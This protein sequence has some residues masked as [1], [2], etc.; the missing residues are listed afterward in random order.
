MYWLL[1]DT[2]ER[3]E[4]VVAVH[5]LTTD[6]AEAKPVP[7]PKTSTRTTKRRAALQAM[8]AAASEQQAASV[9]FPA[10]PLAGGTPKSNG[11]PGRAANG[12]ERASARRAAAAAAAASPGV[13]HDATPMSNAPAPGL[14]TP[15]MGEHP[16]LSGHYH[17]TDMPA[18][19]SLLP[20]NSGLLGGLGDTSAVDEQD[21]LASL[22]LLSRATSLTPAQATGLSTRPRNYGPTPVAA[23]SY[24]SQYPMLSGFPHTSLPVAGGWTPDAGMSTATAVA[25]LPGA[26]PVQSPWGLSGLPALDDSAFPGHRHAQA[27]GSPPSAPAMLVTRSPAMPPNVTEQSNTLTLASSKPSEG[28][29]P[30]VPLVILNAA[31]VGGTSAAPML[32][33]GVMPLPSGAADTH[34]PYTALGVEAVPWADLSPNGVAVLLK[35]HA[36]RKSSSGGSAPEHGPVMCCCACTVSDN[37]AQFQCPDLGAKLPQLAVSVYPAVFRV[38]ASLWHVKNARIVAPLS[39]DFELAF[40]SVPATAAHPGQQGTPVTSQPE[41]LPPPPAEVL[42]PSTDSEEMDDDRL[43]EGQLSVII[44]RNVSRVI[45]QIVKAAT[46]Q[47]SS[48][49]PAS[50]SATPGDAA[51]ASGGPKRGT[52]PLQDPFASSQG[53]EPGSCCSWDALLDADAQGNTLLHYAAL[54]DER[55]LLAW[56]VDMHMDVNVLNNEHVSPLACAALSQNVDVVRKLLQAGALVRVSKPRSDARP[57]VCNAAAYCVDGTGGGRMAA[58]L[59][60]VMQAQDNAGVPASEA[61]VQ[62]Y[63][64]HLAKSGIVTAS[65]QLLNYMDTYKQVLGYLGKMLLAELTTFSMKHR[66]ALAYAL[67]GLPVPNFRPHVARADVLPAPPSSSATDSPSVELLHSQVDLMPSSQDSFA[68]GIAGAAPGGD[69]SLSLSQVSAL[70]TSGD[71]AQGTGASVQSLFNSHRLGVHDSDVLLAVLPTLVATPPDATSAEHQA[72]SDDDES[73]HSAR[74]DMPAEQL[75]RVMKQ[76]SDFER[77][78][79][80]EHVA[81]AKQN[82]RLWLARVA[83]DES[84]LALSIMKRVA[85]QAT[86]R[87]QGDGTAAASVEHD[88]FASR[89]AAL[90]LSLQHAIFINRT[91]RH[92]SSNAV[93]GQPNSSGGGSGYAR[94]GMKRSRTA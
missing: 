84:E 39:L 50:A 67:S 13:P 10:Y 79:V 30:G 46:A 69:G 68:S 49:E 89:L 21:V 35:V 74:P 26:T 6:F 22:R 4:R 80:R 47:S 56:C 17:H 60:K 24:L 61:I 71:V 34:S 28:V 78:D 1:H 45:Q 2:R 55:K 37:A 54:G 86:A 40:D 90:R 72:S 70:F 8:K 65:T 75:R 51:A 87:A 88:S 63:D 20:D 93:A 77:A 14:T 52:A 43:D 57:L 19:Q 3:R 27:L 59:S 33:L 31:V 82:I 41:L 36:H 92:F 23:S 83:R 15:P 62:C 53:G 44:S 12:S 76:L 7:A 9:L 85:R 25:G 42:L 58:T 48:S 32:Q 38:V 29:D 18:S 16:S 91:L 5:Y 64:E 11:H 66:L 81:L 73:D 94:A